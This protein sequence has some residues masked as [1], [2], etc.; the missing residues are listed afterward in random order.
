MAKMYL[1]RYS[2][3]VCAIG[4]VMLFG[5]LGCSASVQKK[6]PPLTANIANKTVPVFKSSPSDIDYLRHGLN[7]LLAQS[8]SAEPDY[9]GASSAF[10]LLVKE[11]PDSKW[12]SA[13]LALIRIINDIRTYTEKHKT[14]QDQFDMLLLEKNALKQS[15]EQIKK[16]ENAQHEK[17]QTELARLAQ[18]NERLKK[19]IESLKEL[20]IKL[21]K[22]ERLLR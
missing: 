14:L 4:L 21:D 1:R 5:I 6:E 22:R 12:T 8:G 10:Q 20:E 18:E 19:D 16:T 2:A 9:V 3:S 11:Y 15:N 17:L 7:L 13:S